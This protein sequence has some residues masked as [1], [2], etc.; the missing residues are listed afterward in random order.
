M[1]DEITI[2]GADLANFDSQQF[3][4][5][6][7][8]AKDEQLS[9]I[10]H[11]PL[12]KQVLDEIFGRMAEH[13]EPSQVAGLEAVVHFKILDRPEEHGGGYDHYEVIFAEGTCRASNDPE[14]DPRVTIKLNGVHFLKLAAS[15]A[16]GP[17][18]FLTGKLKLE[19]DVMLAS[20]LTSFF[21]IP[22]AG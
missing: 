12:R 14:R 20:R 15:R 13:V 19:G 8:T 11:G 17:T 7:A 9:E 18:L 16:S 5:L 1:A 6:I 10:I 21:R 2:A 3:A 4:E 22:S